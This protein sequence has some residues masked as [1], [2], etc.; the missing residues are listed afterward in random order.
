MDFSSG[1]GEEQFVCRSGAAIRPPL[2]DTGVRRVRPPSPI[3]RVDCSKVMGRAAP[4]ERGVRGSCVAPPSTSGG[5]G[6]SVAA[7]GR[8]SRRVAGCV[9]QPPRGGG[10]TSPC[11]RRPRDVRSVFNT[12]DRGE[13]KERLAK[14][15]EKARRPAPQRAQW[16]E[17][18]TCPRAWPS[19][20]C[21]SRIAGVC[22][23]RMRSNDST[24][25]CIVA[26][27]LRRC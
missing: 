12:A 19:L 17:A 9:D 18:N 27:A 2:K 21:P 7:R 13:A 25:N 16:R 5:S 15:V 22:A 23:R 14:L 10:Q 6:S 26:R 4:R 8:A 3:A 11:G 24:A 1:R 20:H